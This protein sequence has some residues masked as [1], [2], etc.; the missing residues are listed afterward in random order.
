ML[1]PWLFVILR[2]MPF[3]SNYLLSNDRCYSWCSARNIKGCE[4]EDHNFNEVFSL[5]PINYVYP[6]TY[7][8]PLDALRGISLVLVL[9]EHWLHGTPFVSAVS[10]GALGLDIFFVLSGFLITG[11]LI[12]YRERDKEEGTGH[13]KSIRTFFIRRVLRIFPMYYLVVIAMTIFNDGMIREALPYNLTYTTN[14]W[15]MHQGHWFGLFGHWWSLAVEEQFY[16]A[17]PFLVLFFKRKWLLPTFALL[18]VLALVSRYML[19]DWSGNYVMAMA[20]TLGCFDCFALGGLLA[21]LNHFKPKLRTKILKRWSIPLL[22]LV[23]FAM[24]KSGFIELD[25]IWTPTL[26][27]GFNAILSFYIIG[28]L[29]FGN[30]GKSRVFFEWKPLIFI[31]QLSYG[32]Y[33]LHNAVPGL[34]MGINTP[35]HG[36]NMVMWFAALTLLAWILN[37][38]Y[39]RPIL[40][41]KKRFVRN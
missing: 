16:L 4:Q 27:R 36:I 15:I 6:V 3:N 11:I 39:E 9:I 32:M 29:A 2:F 7:Y 30:L 37:R 5:N 33:L 34:L 13:G 31:G 20:N 25:Y 19:Y 18:F 10:P 12:R 22:T 8:K 17:W 21:Y 38:I 23:V 28:W 35:W 26:F 41:L 24:L 14:F 40:N 1:S